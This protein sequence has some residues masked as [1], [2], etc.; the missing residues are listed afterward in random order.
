[1]ETVSCCRAPSSMVPSANPFST[2]HDES[3]LSSSL[4]LDPGRDIR[5]AAAG[6]RK[7]AFYDYKQEKTQ[8]QT[9][10][11]LYFQQ[12]Q[13]QSS[14]WNSPIIRSSTWGGN[15]GKTSSVQSFT[16]SHQHHSHQNTSFAPHFIPVIGSR[17][18]F[19]TTGIHTGGMAS[20]DNA[21][22][23]S[24][25]LSPGMSR[26]DLHGI[27]EFA[28]PSTPPRNFQP[29][30]D[31]LADTQDSNTSRKPS[32]CLS[33]QR[34]LLIVYSRS[35]PIVGTIIGNIYDIHQYPEGSRS[36]H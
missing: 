4:E 7:S 9:D 8:R 18:Q 33:R 23:A 3:T 34:L 17:S 19:H 30:C 20:F 32:S 26:C 36:A 13:Q 24:E 12:Q 28:A 21:L 10:A 16:S 22:E 35:Y 15:L 11:K 14:G 27:Q 31:L 29:C 25:I 1:M 2:V 6:E 5:D